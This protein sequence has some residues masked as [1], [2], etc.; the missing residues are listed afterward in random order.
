MTEIVAGFNKIWFVEVGFYN[1]FIVYNK[2]SAIRNGI[3][4]F[5]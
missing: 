3:L 5:E 4:T 2:M 1:S